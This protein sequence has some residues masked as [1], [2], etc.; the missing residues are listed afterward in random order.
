M[1]RKPD[2]PTR[3]LILQG[4]ANVTHRDLPALR[5]LAVGQVLADTQ[6]QPVLHFVSSAHPDQRRVHCGVRQM[7]EAERRPRMPRDVVALTWRR[8]RV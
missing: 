4:P 2:V 6:R 1:R 3:E 7:G 8:E 5:E